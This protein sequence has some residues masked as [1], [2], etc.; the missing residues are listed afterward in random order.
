MQGTFA[1]M[2]T[3]PGPL[4]QALDGLWDRLRSHTPELPPARI[5][6]SPLPPSPKHGWERWER[7]GGVVTGLVV[8]AETLTAGADATLEYVLHEAAH[9]LCW[10]REV[11]ETA[12]YGVYHNAVYL[13]AAGEVGLIWPP[14]QS[15]DARKGYASPVLTRASKV[16]YAD[17]VDAL[18]AAIP[19]IL[20]HLTV[21]EAPMR[22]R[23]ANRLYL[24]CQCAE[25]RRIQI[26]PTVAAKGPV[27]CGVCEK[28]F[29]EQ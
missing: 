1:D 11:T 25:P 17:D 2:S 26:S 13:E 4:L 6:I 10:T 29:T 18:E 21:P 9:M 19:L 24:Q 22:K 7:E 14:T 16:R 20:P 5:A 23:P 12:T 3:S 8:S 15:R 28:P 27:I